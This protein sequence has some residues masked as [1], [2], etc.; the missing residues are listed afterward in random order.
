MNSPLSPTPIFYIPDASIFVSQEFPKP[1]PSPFQS[2]SKESRRTKNPCRS[3]PASKTNSIGGVAVLGRR[4]ASSLFW[5]ANPEQPVVR[6]EWKFGTINSN[7]GYVL[8]DLLLGDSPSLP[9]LAPSSISRGPG[10]LSTNVAGTRS[11]SRLNS[12]VTLVVLFIG[13]VPSLR[14]R[15]T[16]ATCNGT[17]RLHRC[18]RRRRRLSM[19]LLYTAE[20][21]PAVTCAEIRSKP[22]AD[23]VSVSL[24][25]S[26]ANG[27]LRPGIRSST[28]SDSPAVLRGN[29]CC[30][31]FLRG[32]RGLRDRMD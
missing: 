13:C 25:A 28:D 32:G 15:A 16:T 3:P 1:L 26:P 21:F 10:R 2:H 4:T 12:M 20:T 14:R 19:P 30:R 22:A 5:I 17:E 9:P 27:L 8:G 23:V 24:R 7:G 11:F 18:R 6:R 31:G 29:F